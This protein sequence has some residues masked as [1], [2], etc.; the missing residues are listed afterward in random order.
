MLRLNLFFVLCQFLQNVQ[1]SWVE[2]SPVPELI[3][4]FQAAHMNRPRVYPARKTFLS[5]SRVLCVVPGNTDSQPN[6]SAP[7]QL[8]NLQHSLYDPKQGLR[9]LASLGITLLHNPPQN[10]EISVSWVYSLSWRWTWLLLGTPML[11]CA[12]SMAGCWNDS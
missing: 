5:P 4:L 8:F 6:S 3:L 2:N 10:G 9:S 12:H 7:L 11:F 1:A